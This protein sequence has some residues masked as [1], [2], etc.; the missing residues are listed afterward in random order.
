MVC[1]ALAILLVFSTLALSACGGGSD[2]GSNQPPPAPLPP[3]PPPPPPSS[4]DNSIDFVVYISNDDIL[5]P[6][7]ARQDLFA[8]QPETGIRNKLNPDLARGSK[9]FTFAIAPDRSRVSFASDHE[10]PGAIEIYSVNPDGSGLV[11]LNEPL[12][13]GGSVNP[14]GIRWSP[15]SARVAYHGD[16]NGE[17]RT[18]AYSALATGGGIKLSQTGNG[19]TVTGSVEWSPDSSHLVFRQSG[20]SSTLYV[21]AADGVGLAGLSNSASL[22]GAI[23]ENNIQ[24]APDSSRIL[25]FTDE[26]LDVFELFT[27]SPDGSGLT[28]IN[29]NLIQDGDVFGSS[30]LWSPDSSKVVYAANQETLELIEVY[31]VNA[32]GTG[33][34]KLNDAFTVPLGATPASEGVIPYTTQMAPDGTGIS[35]LVTPTHRELYSALL[36]GSQNAKLNG[37]LAGSLNNVDHTSI[38]WS[39]NSSKLLYKANETQGAIHE[40]FSVGPDGLDKN[41]LTMASAV[42]R[43]VLAP[44]ITWAPNGSSVAYLSNQTS[45]A[46]FDLYNVMLDGSVLVRLNN[47]LPAGME[48]NTEQVRWAPDGTHILYQ[49]DT[50]DGTK[51]IVNVTP[52]GS[53]NTPLHGALGS[54]SHIVADGVHWSPDSNWVVYRAD[55]DA[56]EVYELYVSRSDGSANIKVNVPLSA[57]QRIEG[58]YVWAP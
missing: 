18:H 1:R 17:G 36:D 13:S 53:T 56:D 49:I 26:V 38:R 37:P 54:N 9:V 47:D 52:D 40:L 42:A 15:D 48:I 25:F 44:S 58:S 6:N 51:Q 23:F 19:N 16:L 35:Y 41:V 57:N 3:P 34:I 43:A 12:T 55:Q 32:N 4:F 46:V 14:F 5:N 24:W 11:K 45:S 27:V 2:G 28:K 20:G 8:Y 10:T 22:R 39:P 29:G 30:V 33:R 31:S 50:V 7:L 21:V